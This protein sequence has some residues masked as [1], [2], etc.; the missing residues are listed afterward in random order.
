MRK[1]SLGALV[2]LGLTASALTG[3]TQSPSAE[4]TTTWPLEYNDLGYTQVYAQDNGA[5]AAITCGGGAEFADATYLDQLDADQVPTNHTADD[6]YCNPLSADSKMAANGVT[7]VKGSENGEIYL[8]AFRNGRQLWSSDLSASVD[9]DPYSGYV[10]EDNWPDS[11]AIGADGNLYMILSPV[12]SPSSCADRVV[13]M[14]VA[15]G[16]IIEETTIGSGPTVSGIMPVVPQLWTYDDK[17][18]VVDRD[19]M[20]REYDYD[21]VEDTGARYTFP[22]PTNLGIWSLVANEEGTVF[23]TTY[24]VWTVN[25]NAPILFHKDDG[26]Y[27]SFTDRPYGGSTPNVSA[28]ANGGVAVIWEN[29]ISL[30]NPSNTS[31]YGTLTPTIP[32]G[33]NSSAIKDYIEDENGNAIIVRNLGKSNGDKAVL[34]E[35][36]DAATGT[37]EELLFLEE[38]IDVDYPVVTYISSDEAISNGFLYLPICYG[39]Y[40]CQYAP[41]P[42]ERWIHKIELDTFGTPITNSHQKVTYESDKLEYVAMGDSYSSGE[43]NPPFNT[44]T[45][46]FLDNSCHR[47]DNAYGKILTSSQY[48]DLNLRLTDFVACSG[49]TIDDVMNGSVGDEPQIDALSASTDVVTITIGGNDAGFAYY[50]AECILFDC[51]PGSSLYDEIMDTIHSTDYAEQLEDLYSSILSRVTN[52]DAKIYVVGYPYVT[53]E[54]PFEDVSCLGFSGIVL[55]E[56]ET[57]SEGA[58]DVV[59]AM[60]QASVDAMATLPLNDKF[61]F[62]DPNL[63]GSPFEEHDVCSSV[64]YF[65]YPF[66]EIAYHN[67]Y[68]PNIAGQNAYAEVVAGVINN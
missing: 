56:S 51:G 62:I 19:G 40:W 30:F 22:V 37:P 26:T 10:D 24:W 6:L 5:V 63:T 44:W 2:A 28:T 65:V 29:N 60:N 58:R 38:G 49:A 52:P 25:V 18:V 12:S 34:V 20:L 31:T 11:I 59:A 64:P 4:A 50:A 13:K 48:N 53:P 41:I 32:S 42:E 57:D 16:E 46:Q 55:G 17:I 1:R 33:Y 66:A 23:A 3:I 45:D 54:D 43:G 21:L 14:D 36:I 27:G 39:Q 35:E 9:C 15:S 61:L 68:H 7:Y 8:Y 47:S 67:W